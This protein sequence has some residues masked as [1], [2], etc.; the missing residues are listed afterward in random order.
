MLTNAKNLKNQNATWKKSADAAMS[1]RA[2]MHRT[3]DTGEATWLIST[4]G[5]DHDFQAAAIA[6][7]VPV[8]VMTPVGNGGITVWS[9]TPDKTKT[10]TFPL[11]P[12]Y[13]IPP[14]DI[15]CCLTLE[16]NHYKALKMR[17]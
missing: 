15:V 16:R 10:A 9:P 11:K 13:H 5:G 7:G 1:R 12:D 6:Y 4:W 17:R 2:K 14:E 3:I 8:H